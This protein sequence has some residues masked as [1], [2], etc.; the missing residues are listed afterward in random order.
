MAKKKS[1]RKVKEVGGEQK[2]QD[3][4]AAASEAEAARLKAIFSEVE[5]AEIDLDFSEK[6]PTEIVADFPQAEPF[7]I[8]SGDRMIALTDCHAIMVDKKTGKAYA[9]VS[10]WNPKKSRA[11]ERYQSAMDKKAAKEAGDT[12]KSLGDHVEG[13][14]AAFMRNKDI[15]EAELHINFTTPCLRKGEGCYHK[16]PEMLPPSAKLT[17]FTK[18]DKELPFTGDLDQL[19]SPS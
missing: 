3:P 9:I 19:R 18:N 17:V 4:A 2:C 6:S 14:T 15:D 16:L 1:A 5:L 8:R 10:G 12:W 11:D 13:Q 7:F